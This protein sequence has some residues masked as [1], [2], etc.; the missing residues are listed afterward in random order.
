MSNGTFTYQVIYGRTSNRHPTSLIAALIEIGQPL[1]AVLWS[2]PDK[3]W[4]YA[5][6]IAARRLYDDQYQ[7]SVDPVDRQTA[8]QIASEFLETTLPGEET[9]LRLCQEGQQ[10]GLSWGPRRS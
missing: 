3:A 4:T 8:E 2:R 10:A 5:P 1:Q 9:L 7:D 6:A